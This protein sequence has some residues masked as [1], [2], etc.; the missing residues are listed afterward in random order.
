[1]TIRSDNN[2]AAKVLFVRFRM[3]SR[4]RPADFASVRRA[5]FTLV[6][7]LPPLRYLLRRL[8]ACCCL[9]ISAS[10]PE[11]VSAVERWSLA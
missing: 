8:A 6:G 11:I 4:R 5:C 7:L 3:I 9:L 10:L 2:T 1:V